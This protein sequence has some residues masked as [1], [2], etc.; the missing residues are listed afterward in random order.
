MSF[1]RLLY[2]R[3]HRLGPVV[4]GIATVSAAVGADLNQT[5]DSAWPQHVLRAEA[6]YSLNVPGGRRFDASGLLLAREGGLLTLRDQGPTLY[7][8]ELRTA[9]NAANLRPL[10]NCF[11]AEQLKPFSPRRRGLYD[12]EGIAQDEQGRLYICEEG[13][14]WILRCELEAGRVERLAIDWSPVTN[15]FSVDPNASFEGLAIGDG[16]LYLA[17]E[18]SAP[19]IIAVDLASLKV[20]DH[21]VV[22]PQKSSLFGTHYSDLSWWDHR[23]FVLCRQHQVVLEVEPRTHTAL[24]EYDYAEAENQFGYG[25]FGMVG[26]MEGLAVDRDCFWLVIDNNGLA[27]HGT[28][29]DTRPVLLKCP[30]PGEGTRRERAPAQRPPTANPAPPAR[31]RP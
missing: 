17:N 26:M 14:R 29:N 10:T 8:I 12:C 6:A 27:R 16:R 4:L 18:R 1:R 23:L 21:F 2:L 11:T 25:T 31:M 13:N 22:L 19:V 24:G 3:M 9:T 15:Y 30:R 20:V 5:N 28:R 7:R